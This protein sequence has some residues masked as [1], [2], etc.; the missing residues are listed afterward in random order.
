MLP[1]SA[2]SQ[3]GEM[4]PLLADS[5][6][7]DSG[8]RTWRLLTTRIPRHSHSCC[9]ESLLSLPGTPGAGEQA[10]G[11]PR[12]CLVGGQCWHR[13]ESKGWAEPRKGP[14]LAQLAGPD[15]DYNEEGRCP[16]GQ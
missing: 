16:Q 3:Q 14:F 13:G 15:E 8:T 9:P 12:A 10:R 1:L 2:P 6:R 4:R 5:D 7:G 11:L